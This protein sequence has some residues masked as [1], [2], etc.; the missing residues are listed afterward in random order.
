MLGTT[1]LDVGADVA[2][3][4][5]NTRLRAK[6]RSRSSG[7]AAGAAVG[8]PARIRVW[9]TVVSARPLRRAAALVALHLL[10]P[11]MRRPHSGPVALL[12]GA[13]V[14]ACSQDSA[15]AV[16]RAAATAAPTVANAN[17][18]VGATVGTPLVYDATKG[19]AVVADAAAGGLTY[20]LAFSGPANGLRA[21]GG[22]ITGT[23][24]A[25]GLTTA[26]LTATDALGRTV[27]DRFA[28]VAF[29]SG[30]PA[31]VLPA[32]P[33]RYADAEVP[34]PTHFTG[35]VNG[36]TVT[37]ADNTPASNPITDAGATLGRVLFYDPR[38]SANDGIACA[39]CHIQALGFSDV[40]RLSVGFA[41]GSTARHSPGLANARFYQRGHFF[42]DE[43]AATLEDQV[44][45]PIQ[46]T[47]EMGTTLDALVM[48]LTATPYYGPLFTS[49]FGTPAVTSDRIARALAQYVRSLVSAGS[50]YDRAYTATGTANFAATLTAEEQAGE[51]LFRSTGC[52]ACHTT[53]AQVGDGVHNIGLDAVVT[54]TGA[55]GGAFKVPSLRN[56]GVRPRFMHDGRFTTLAQVV[57]FF[58]AGVQATPGL[59]ARLKAADGSPKRLGLTAAEKAAL[60]AYLN[61][62][63]DSTFLTAPRFAS[64]FVA[65]TAAPP[66]V[67]PPTSVTTTA[68]VT[69]Q[70]TAYH[71]PA[72]TVAPGTSIVFTN[73]DNQR[74][75]ASFASARIVS[76]PIFT[77]GSRTVVMP[78]TPGTYPY[79]CAVHGAAMSGTVIVK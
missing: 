43:R 2:Y 77:S 8:E 79:Q 29:A 48:K 60:V 42:W 37:T 75:S 76:T 17:V 71:P 23:P 15:T 36:T 67:P 31:P 6:A 54:D 62:L 1:A 32:V 34:L 4:A 12:V 64:P 47:T 72:I 5:D 19:G 24:T 57:D 13:A 45:Q 56:V 27:D 59:D 73:L 63:T 18:V 30:L 50:R 66:T 21:V 3:S 41:G 53:V 11:S 26:T 74:H 35:S 9:Q 70:N 55:G 10:P 51:Q 22:T 78:A 68:A 44:V 69:I 33:F 25:P 46:N 16:R 14:T 40:P 28:V 38:L 52:A 61:T 58:D 7:G 65:G 49:A 20:T 39:G